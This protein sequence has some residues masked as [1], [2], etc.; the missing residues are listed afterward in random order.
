MSDSSTENKPSQSEETSR[1]VRHQ[2]SYGLPH[3]FSQ[4]GIAAWYLIG[5]G[6]VL[7]GTVILVDK[8]MLVFVS[9]F[10]SLMATAVFRPLTRFLDRFLPRALATA[11]SM[12][13]LF[14]VSGGV[15]YYVF[16][17]VTDSWEELVTMVSSGSHDI[18]DFLEHGPLPW[19]LTREE[20]INGI[21]N[22]VDSGVSNLKDDWGAVVGKV[23]SN[24]G[25]VVSVITVLLTTIFMT[26]FFVHSGDKM[27]LWFINLLPD[28]KR[29]IVHKAALAGWETFADYVRGTFIVSSV[30]AI[31]SFALLWIVGVPLAGPLAVLI[32]I[33]AFV[34]LIGIPVAMVLAAL[35]AFATK[36]GTAALIILI[37]IIIISQLEANLLKP[38]V[39]GQQV[40]I[41]PVLVGAG[42]VAGTMLAGVYG[43]IV[44]IPLMAVTWAVVKVLY[45]PDKPL[46]ELPKVVENE[47][48]DPQEG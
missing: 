12:V 26:V 14:G 21:T 46:E 16:W 27:W 42:V 9:F 3:R 8:T 19:K 33:G 44:A 37:G 10:L 13:V 41:H 30:D 32:F 1:S 7:L 47:D 34:P 17:S 28:E 24:A 11:L 20:I 23:V 35:V 38:L 43:A 4:V 15:I 39:M 40:Q 29:A 48:V 5:I 18:F 45:K 36:G 6:I 31:A 2:D 25:A 22:M